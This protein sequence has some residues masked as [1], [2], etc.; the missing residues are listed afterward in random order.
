MNHP[1]SDH[2]AVP[3]HLGRLQSV[4]ISDKTKPEPQITGAEEENIVFVRFEGEGG[5]HCLPYFIALDHEK[6]AVVLAIRGTLS[7]QDTVTGA[8]LHSAGPKLQCA[9]IA[10]CL[11]CA[12]GISMH[13]QPAA[14]LTAG[15]LTAQT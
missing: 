2:F 1:S 12:V 6:Q 4:Q 15:G 3:H 9:C 5:Q 7:L 13:H 11:D 8:C 14:C 10:Y